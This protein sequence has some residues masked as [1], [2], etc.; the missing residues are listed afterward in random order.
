M[1]N[2]M[3]LK[4]YSKVKKWIKT[5]SGPARYIGTEVEDSNG[6][7]SMNYSTSAGEWVIHDGK[8]HHVYVNSSKDKKVKKIPSYCKCKTP[9]ELDF[10]A[11]IDSS[12]NSVNGVCSCGIWKH[13]IHCN[14][15]GGVTQ[16]G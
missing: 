8:K 9:G 1:K 15:C 14:K 7:W 6:H 10:S 12:G 13:H 2:N 5:A 3:A 16:V 4:K 11:F